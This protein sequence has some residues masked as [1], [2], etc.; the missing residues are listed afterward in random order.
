MLRQDPSECLFSFICSSNNHISRIHGMVNKM[1]VHYGDALPV[2]T[3][4]LEEDDDEET[5]T[6]ARRPRR[7][8]RRRNFMRFRALRRFLTARRRRKL[9]ALG[10]GYR[11]K[12][13]VGSAAGFGEGGRRRRL[14]SRRILARASRRNAVRRRPRRADDAP[15]DRS[16]SIRLRVSCSP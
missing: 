10:F 13:I 14:F 1:C 4:D 3:R 6:A 11:A 15:G 8:P 2:T 9:R 5:R 16:Q 7:L 12:F